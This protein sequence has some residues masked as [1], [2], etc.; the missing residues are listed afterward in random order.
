MVLRQ[1]ARIWMA[2]LIAVAGFAATVPDSKLA[3]AAMDRDIAKVRS[4]LKLHADVNA[5]QADG[6]TALHW[7]ARWNNPE[8]ADLLIRAGANV[9][10]Q[11]RFGAT[12]LL[13]A[14]MNGS[15]PVIEKLLQAGDDP[16]AVISEKGDTVLMIAARTGKVDAIQVLLDHGAQVDKTNREGQTALMWAVAEKNAAATQLLIEHKADVNARTN[17]LPAPSPFQ[18]IFSA[19]FPAGG[20]TPLLYAARQNDFDSARILLD[21]HADV[22]DTSADGSSPLLVAI[23][24]GHDALAKFLLDQGANPNLADDKGRAALYAAVDMRNLEWSTRPAPPEK[25]TLSELDLI[26]A[27]L[28]H[29]ANPNARLA[30]KI[31][32]RGQPSFDGRWAN[33]IGAT[34]FWR[35]AQSDDVTVM[36]LL[37]DHGADPLIAANDRTTPLMVA[38]GVGWSDGQSHGSQA[39]APEALRLCI[40]WGGDVNAVNEEGYT[41]LHGA[42]FR[43]ANEVVQFLVEHGAKMDVKNKD[44]RTPINMAEGMHI[45]PGGWVEH[46]DTVALF[47]K[48]MA[49]AKD[50]KTAN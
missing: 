14:A 19:P 40:Q 31:P 3:D 25:D 30:K 27:L 23:L 6:T 29:G 1:A 22:N 10:A 13:L 49:Q 28:E 47:R 5:P 18:L 32:L 16:N 24:N 35:A 37:V 33:Q 2:A 36:K 8:M 21:A 34:P 9:K 39:D 17:K 45:G 44:G 26:K 4:L 7:A 50:Q 43:G 46:D 11:N 38:A 48:L 12:P 42:S 20:M 41:A 15:A